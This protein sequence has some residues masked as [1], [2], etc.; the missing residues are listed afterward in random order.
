MKAKQCVSDVDNPDLQQV[1]I[2]EAHQCRLNQKRLL[3]LKQANL[4]YKP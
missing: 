4:K 3:K 2:E 1:F